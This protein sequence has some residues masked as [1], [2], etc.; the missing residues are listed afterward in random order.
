MASLEADVEELTDTVNTLEQVV[1]NLQEAVDELKEVVEDQKQQIENH[2][3][4]IVALTDRLDGI[5]NCPS[6]SDHDSEVISSLLERVRDL[7]A[8]H[9]TEP[10]FPS[11]GNRK[12]RRRPN[13][14]MLRR[15]KRVKV[16]AS[17]C[18]ADGKEE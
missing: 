10:L 13:P 16:I 17:S 9:P 18:K 15:S 12:R 7:E 14:P 2:E 4:Q 1:E 5:E 3:S 8:L 6:D 11:A